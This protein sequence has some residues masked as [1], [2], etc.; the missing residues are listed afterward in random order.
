MNSS[1]PENPNRL[2]AEPLSQAMKSSRNGILKATDLE[3]SHKERLSAAGWLT[4]IIRGWYLLT[5]PQATGSD[6]GSTAWFGGFWAFLGFYLSDRFGTEGYCLGAES[7]LDL[8]AGE[9]AIARQLTVVTRKHSNQT[10]EL[11]HGTSLFLYSDNKNFPP[12]TDKKN[13]VNIMPLPLALSR[14]SPAYYTGKPINVQIALRLLP[15]AAEISRVLL[16]TQSATAASRIA[17]AYEALG[18]SKQARQIAEDMAAAGIVLKPIHPFEKNV[19]LLQSRKATSPYATRIE[20]LW[21]RMRP[22]VVKIFP[23]APGLSRAEKKT[24]KI[25]RELYTEDAYHSLSIEGYQVTEALI[26][27]IAGGRWNPESSE[28]D[29]NQMNA[30]AA[31]GYH[32]AF[33][34]VLR[35]VQ[36][37]FETKQTAGSIFEDDLQDWYRKLFTPSVQVGS[38]RASDLAGYRNAPVYIRNSRHVPPPFSAVTDAMEKLFE[39]LIQEESAAAR[40][41]LGHFFFVYIHPYR[42]G[43]GRIGRFLMN[44]MLVSGGYDWTVIR[45]EKRKEYMAA[46]EQASVH[47]EIGP[48]SKFIRSIIVK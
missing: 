25:I 21:N 16:E 11:P 19:P 30:L 27:K 35:S 2:L 5:P 20:A 1:L 7:S 6:G 32:D 44:F 26:E 36:K 29:R 37:L 42:D 23:K 22:N 14:L 9:T 34:A 18:E 31:K 13:G 8:H 10:V 17:G 3:R 41:V 24:I 12:A 47:E 28:S 33:E 4:E 46:L 40:A 38:L 48:F 43:N 39:L 15:T 45:V